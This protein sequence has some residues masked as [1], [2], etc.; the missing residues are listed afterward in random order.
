MNDILKMIPI[1]IDMIDNLRP[2]M[3]RFR[4]R[5]QS[6]VDWFLEESKMLV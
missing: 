1:V 2:D 5:Y 6:D 3:S 4:F